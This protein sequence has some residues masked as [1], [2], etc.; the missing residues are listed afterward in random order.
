MQHQAKADHGTVQK[1]MQELTS[2][3]LTCQEMSHSVIELAL[4]ALEDRVNS[5]AWERFEVAS[6]E[7]GRLPPYW[8]QILCD[9]T[10][11]KLS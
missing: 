3:A 5:V 7:T 11:C 6:D 2:L 10:S 1:V 4:P 9:P 8:S